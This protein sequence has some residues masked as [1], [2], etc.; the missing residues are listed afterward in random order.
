M[1]PGQHVNQKPSKKNDA[2]GAAG[3][4]LAVIGGAAICALP[5]FY[6]GTMADEAT[7][8]PDRIG[9]RTVLGTIAGAGIGGFLI[10]GLMNGF[11][12][13]M[14]VWIVGFAI[15]GA[16]VGP[17]CDAD[18]VSSALAGALF[19]FFLAAISGKM[20]S[21]QRADSPGNQSLNRSGRSG[22]N[23]MER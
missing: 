21:S 18:P 10:W 8:G 4:M 22:G 15:A 9:I 6:F 16:L 20:R 1:N 2:Y 5:F 19:G 23:Q 12:G 11:I 17:G 14:V 13:D 3:H 7:L